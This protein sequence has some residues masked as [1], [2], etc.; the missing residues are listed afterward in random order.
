[1]HRGHIRL[2]R[3]GARSA[4]SHA[5][6]SYRSNLLLSIVLEA[7]ILRESSGWEPASDSGP[8]ARLFLRTECS[9]NASYPD[10]VMLAS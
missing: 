6:A 9:V 7:V 1:M 4:L 10:N 8:V 5:S 2:Y 3:Y